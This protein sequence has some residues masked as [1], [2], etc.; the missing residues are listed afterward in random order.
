[1]AGAA[2]GIADGDGE[3]GLDGAVGLR[4]EAVGDDGIEGGLDEFHHQRIR[5][6]ERTGG[7]AG[8]A[9]GGACIG[10]AGEAEDAGWQIQSR[11]EFEQRLINRTEFLGAH[12]PVVDGAAFTA[13]L[14]EE[15][16]QLPHGGKDVAIGERGAVEVGALAVSKESSEGGQGETRLAVGEGLEH[17]A[18][19]EPEVAMRVVRGL[20]EGA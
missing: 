6:V 8:I 16:A 20:A 5:G 4:G 12:V 2:G 18:K 14:V 3:E 7:L 9:R 19:T 15:P 1:V 11:D 13:F 10:D 17:D